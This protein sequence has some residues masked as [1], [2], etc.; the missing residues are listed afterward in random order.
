[1]SDTPDGYPIREFSRLTGVNPVTL[2]AWER[3]YGIIRPLRTPKGHRFYNDDHVEL[4]RNILYWLEQGYPIR[5]VKLLLQTPASSH[6]DDADDWHTQQDQ[7]L[8]ACSRFSARGLDDLLQQGLASYP[9]AVYWERCLQP[10]LEHLRADSHSGPVLKSFAYLLKRKLNSLI[11]LQQ[12][13]SEGRTLLMATNHSDAELQVLAITYALGAAGFRVE[14]F[15]SE[16]QPE[17]IRILAPVVSVSWI[18]L[19]LHPAGA[20]E[21]RA[22]HSIGNDGQIP[23]FLSGDNHGAPDEL[24]VMP[25][26]TGAMITQFITTSGEPV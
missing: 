25:E 8:R 26:R 18:W 16:L 21:S 5:Q 19:H 7:I 15:G 17:D 2:R 20:G 23:V 1:M 9:M 3:R 22:W 6:Q 12:K 4:V 24:Y 11:A 14:Y 10:V 13:H